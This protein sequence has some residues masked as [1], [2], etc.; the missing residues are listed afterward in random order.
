MGEIDQPTST[1]PA[2]GQSHWWRQASGIAWLVV[3]ILFLAF[4]VAGS[5]PARIWR[6]GSLYVESKTIAGVW[7][8]QLRH[9]PDQ[10]PDWFMKSLFAGSLGVFVIA[11]LVGFRLLLMPEPLEEG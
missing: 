5:V 8:A 3:S 10:F 6:L 11:V 1:E 2:T 7:A 9:L 4:L